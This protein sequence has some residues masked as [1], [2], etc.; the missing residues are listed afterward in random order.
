MQA[1]VAKALKIDFNAVK[2]TS[3]KP[4]SVVVKMII[5]ELSD[6]PKPLTELVA[7][8]KELVTN[9]ESDLYKGD[10][11]TWMQN[12][13]KAWEPKVHLSFCSHQAHPST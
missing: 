3:V 11:F 7:D 12:A 4:G 1:D 2:I 13:D 5:R 10:G 8:L 9:S 6:S